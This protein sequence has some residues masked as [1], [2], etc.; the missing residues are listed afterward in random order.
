MPC[1]Q[2]NILKII[3][4]KL[5]IL[6]IGILIISSCCKKSND[7]I[8]FNCLDSDGK[9]CIE[10]GVCKCKNGYFAL[11]ESKCQKYSSNYYYGIVE[12]NSCVDTLVMEEISEDIFS[13][14]NIVLYVP[15]P[16]P[17]RYGRGIEAIDY[18]NYGNGTYYAKTFDVFCGSDVER[19]IT[20]NV[21][22]EAAILKWEKVDKDHIFMRMYFFHKPYSNNNIII[23]DSAKVI[24]QHSVFY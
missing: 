21:D 16:D 3:L 15:N 11:E 24:L 6:I 12:G 17:I 13:S 22:G 9:E 19:E 10:D 7:P 1:A 20:P 5:Y 2:A 4:M 8:C 14:E 23:T 18:I